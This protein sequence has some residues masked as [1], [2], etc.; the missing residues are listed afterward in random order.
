MTLLLGDGEPEVTFHRHDATA[1]GAAAAKKDAT[2]ATT[3]DGAAAEAAT[4]SERPMQ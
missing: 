1:T 4:P 3:S 2:G